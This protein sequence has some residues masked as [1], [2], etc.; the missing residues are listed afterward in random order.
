VRRPLEEDHPQARKVRLVCDDLNTRNI[1][2]LCEAYPAEE[3]HRLARRQEIVSTPRNGRRQN[4]AEV[5][6]SVPAEQCL[7]R[8][9]ATAAAVDAECAAWERARNAEGSRVVWRLITADARIK[10]R[11]LYPQV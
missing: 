6:R 5:E 3:A 9:M 7:A 1:A 10:L 4:V 11:H 2:W 8:Q